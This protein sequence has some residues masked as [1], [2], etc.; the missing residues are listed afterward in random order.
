MTRRIW[1]LTLTLEL[2]RLSQTVAPLLVSLLENSNARFQFCLDSDSNSDSRLILKA[3]FRFWFQVYSVYILTI[4]D[5][6]QQCFWLNSFPTFTFWKPDSDSRTFADVWFWFRF[7]SKVE[8]FQNQF[9]FHNR[10]RASLLETDETD[11][12]T[13]TADKTSKKPEWLTGGIKLFFCIKLFFISRTLPIW[14]HTGSWGLMMGHKPHVIPQESNRFCLE[15]YRDPVVI[16][17][18]SCNRT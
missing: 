7:Q 16:Q 8:S 10:S 17:Q 9:R 11:S 12:I 13:V 5:N 18:G 14:C 15:S 2:S 1:P 3:W 6:K 4:S